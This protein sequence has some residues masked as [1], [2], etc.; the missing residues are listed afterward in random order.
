[1][2]FLEKGILIFLVFFLTVVI[3]TV[4]LRLLIFNQSYYSLQ[5]E[6]NNVDVEDKE[7]I[8]ANI[9][10]FFNGREQLNYFD[11]NE[12]FH[13]N[14]VKQLLNKFFL[15]LNL[16]LVLSFVLLAS[17]FFIDKKTFVDN[18]LKVLFLSGLCSFVVILLLLLTLF[19]FSTT[20]DGF[21]KLFFSQGNYSFSPSSLLIS[22]FS[23][24]FFKSFFLKIV[25]NSLILSIIF[26]TPQLV[27]N[28]I[29]K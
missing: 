25:F 14:D 6:R 22:L 12:Q 10:A 29:K 13:M 2:K 23:E 26:M 8:V 28:R 9:L 4:P 20:F 1:M 27:L 19:N 7:L 16:S 21:H 24:N 11:E 3:L 18:F 15:A 17:L 5:F